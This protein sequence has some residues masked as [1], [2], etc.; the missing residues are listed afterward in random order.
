MPGKLHKLA[1]DVKVEEE[2]IYQKIQENKWILFWDKFIYLT[3][4]IG[5]L[6]T[7]PQIYRVWVL[8]HAEINTLMIYVFFAG[9]SLAWLIYGLIHKKK[10]IILT[11][12]GWVILNT[13]MVIGSQMFR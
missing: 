5:L 6:L 12:L 9:I 13:F 7:I 8:K 11:N 2:K 3:A 10:A 4:F 1:T